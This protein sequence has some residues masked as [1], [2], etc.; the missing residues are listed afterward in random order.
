MAKAKMIGMKTKYIPNNRAATP[1]RK[2]N[3]MVQ[4]LGKHSD[5]QT[6]VKRYFETKEK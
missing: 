1:G 3:F 6:L 4:Q 2:K 5:T